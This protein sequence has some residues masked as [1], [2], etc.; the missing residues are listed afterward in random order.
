MVFKIFQIII[1][2]SLKYILTVPYAL[3][4]GIEYKYAMPA[5]VIGGIGG[6]LFFYYLSKRVVRLFRKLLP[7]ACKIMPD[8]I[9]SRYS[10]LC[11]S[12]LKPRHKPVFS[13][14]NRMII[15]LKKSYGL[16]GIVVTTPVLLSIP[17]G[18]FLASHY[19]SKDRRVIV[20]MLISIVGWGAIFSSLLLLFPGITD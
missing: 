5:I 13:R 14:R 6:F 1:L 7:L 11:A 4:I 17:V 20:Y 9:K 16:W 3:L 8:G 10:E 15:R 18:A 19:Y 2:A 12:W